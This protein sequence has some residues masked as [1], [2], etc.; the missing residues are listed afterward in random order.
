MKMMIDHMTSWQCT[1]FQD[2]QAVFDFLLE[3]VTIVDE[4]MLKIQCP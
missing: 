3:H 2:A 1:H 4:K